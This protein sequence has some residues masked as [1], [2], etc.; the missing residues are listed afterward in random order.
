MS[1]SFLKISKST[2]PM[3]KVLATATLVARLMYKIK[4]ATLSSRVLQ[5]VLMKRQTLKANVLA[6]RFIRKFNLI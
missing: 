6:K 5:V 4:M 3:A 2:T 1:N